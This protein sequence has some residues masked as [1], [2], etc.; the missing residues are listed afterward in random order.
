MAAT[1]QLAGKD[2]GICHVVPLGR[3]GPYGMVEWI[4]PHASIEEVQ[5]SGDALAFETSSA[6][7]VDKELSKV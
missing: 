6:Q 2:G 7:K 3:N 5:R 4:T 1:A